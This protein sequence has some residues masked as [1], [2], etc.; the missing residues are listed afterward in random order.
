MTSTAPVSSGGPTQPPSRH[1][2]RALL[3]APDDDMRSFLQALLEQDARFLLVATA[4]SGGEAAATAEREQPDAVVV[5]VQ[6]TGGEGLEAVAAL[7]RA[8][9]G[10]RI[11][12]C[13]AFPDAY[14]LVDLLL[15][16]ADGYI[17]SALAWSELLPTLRGLCGLSDA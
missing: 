15:H 11:V 1:A 3:V 9:P 17:N 6:S 4:V 7:R 12:V 2:V 16:G 14:T 8:V 13:S 10:G 5:D